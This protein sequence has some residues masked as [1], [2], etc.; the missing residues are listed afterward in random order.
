MTKFQ[1][2]NFALPQ[3]ARKG[4]AHDCMDARGRAMP[5]A[6]AEGGAA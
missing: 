3:A 1:D 6:I 5:G 4:A 2:R